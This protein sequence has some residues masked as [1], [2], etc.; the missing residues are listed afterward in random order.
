MSRRE[1]L[2]QAFDVVSRHETRLRE[3]FLS[4][5]SE[6]SRVKV[7]GS[8]C[9]DNR[10]STFAIGVSDMDPDTLTRKLCERNLYC[11]S[12][13]HYCTLGRILLTSRQ[14]TQMMYSYDYTQH[15]N[16]TTGTFWNDALGLSNEHGATRMGFL[17]YNTEED[18]DAILSE[19][20]R[21][22]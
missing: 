6:M 13:N 7:Y 9:V 17:H 2:V 16:V 14:E 1:A 21:I 19:L 12:G 8:N 20:E 11:T 22:V 3:K 4:G 10:T 18:V 15:N 5:I